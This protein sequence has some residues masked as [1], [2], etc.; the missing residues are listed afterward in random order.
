MLKRDIL[1][2]SDEFFSVH[3][4]GIVINFLSSFNFFLYFIMY[5]L[6]DFMITK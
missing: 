2:V 3:D 4:I 5:F 1:H 6:Y